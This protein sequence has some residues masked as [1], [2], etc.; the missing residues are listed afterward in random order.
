MY[1]NIDVAYLV[2]YSWV[3]QPLWPERKCE[4]TVYVFANRDNIR[5]MRLRRTALWARYL[6]CIKPPEPT[7]VRCNT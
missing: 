1:S 3:F 6:I 2:I 5:T 4:S 7:V